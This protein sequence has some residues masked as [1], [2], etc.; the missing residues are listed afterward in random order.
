MTTSALSGVRII[1]FTHI[2]AGPTCTQQLAWLGADV[3][4]VELPGKG[5]IT[6]SQLRDR[7]G[8][9]SL[10]FTMLNHNKRSLTLDLKTEQGKDI[11]A[12]LLAV[13]DVLVENFSDGV[14]DRLGFDWSR[15][16]DINPRLIL[17]SIKGFAPGPYQTAKLFENI[18]QCVGGSASTT[19]HMYEPPMTTS[20]QIGDVGTG[21]QLA[22]GVVSALYQRHASGRGQRVTANMQD[23]VMNLLRI[24]LRDQLRIEAGCD[25][26]EYAKT[27]HVAQVDAVPRTG[28]AHRSFQPGKVV[29]C[30]G[31]E[32]DANSYLYVQITNP[33]WPDLCR[34]IGRDE[35]IHDPDFQEGQLRYAKAEQIFHQIESW[36]QKLDKFHAWEQL[37]ALKIPSGPVM[38]WKDIAHAE[39]LKQSGSIVTVKHPHRGDHVTVGNPLRMSDSA[40][41]IQRAPLLGEHTQHILAELGYDQA[42]VHHMQQA[43]VI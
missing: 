21:V 31:W 33:I 40:V 10:Y 42:T 23:S 4:K 19:G 38:S 13:S 8:V 28:N 7:P 29:K 3:I 36:S 25:L 17:A 18:A 30:R 16:Q 15:I 37:L 41:D 32:S 35:W 5:D 2:Q 27:A 24:K 26:K 9:D 34:L 12:R 6:R 14:L 22:L 39:W 20:A 11:F 43:G 1:D